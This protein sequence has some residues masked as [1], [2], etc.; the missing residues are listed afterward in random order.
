MDFF[1]NNVIEALRL[2]EDPRLVYSL[3]AA[4]LLALVSLISGWGRLDFLALARPG[5]LLRLGLGVAAAF[6][7]AALATSAP[8]AANSTDGLLASL[9][10][11]LARLPLY[12]LALAYGPTIGL[13]AGALFAAA[14]AAGPF[15]GWTEAI[16]TL[17]L[18][19]LGWLAISPSPRRTRLAGPM[20]AS[21]AYLLASGT[22]GLA[23]HVWLTGGLSLPVLLAEHALVLPGLLLAWL[24]LTA[25]GPGL[26]ARYLPGSRIDPA[27]LGWPTAHDGAAEPPALL[28]PRRPT[29]LPVPEFSGLERRSR[30]RGRRLVDQV[31]HS[32]DPNA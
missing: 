15:P 27:W 7:L 8:V 24:L 14:T 10:L 12:I 23:H 19:I 1:L 4:A 29:A 26:Y 20:G 6:G 25:V 9:L 17:E 21:L 11:G 28:T 22:A 32:E 18:V 2:G 30:P 31:W 13:L 3:A 16:L 5:N